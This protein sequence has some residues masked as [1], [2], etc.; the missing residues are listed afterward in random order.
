[1][2]CLS[3]G[4]WLHGQVLRTCCSTPA[5]RIR[6]LRHDFLGGVIGC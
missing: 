3:G 1:M 2:A 4:E 6:C 5:A